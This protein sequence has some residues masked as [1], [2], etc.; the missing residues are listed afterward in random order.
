[1]YLMEKISQKKDAKLLLS[2]ALVSRLFFDTMIELSGSEQPNI[3]IDTSAKA[4]LGAFADTK[5]RFDGHF[6]TLKLSPPTYLE[7]ENAHKSLS[8]KQDQINNAD[9]L[10]TLGGS[11]QRIYENWKS[12]GLDMQI[13]DRVTR[14]KLVAA[15]ASAG[16]MIWFNNGF[17]DSMAEEVEEDE[18]WD[19]MKS[20][21]LE[22]LPYVVTAHHS[23]PDEHGRARDGEFKRFLD[24]S[25][26]V[27]EWQQAIGI[28]TCAG[29]LC[30]DGLLRVVDLKKNAS[31]P[32]ELPG[33]EVYVYT[34]DIS[35]VCSVQLS[36]GDIL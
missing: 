17:S 23:D 36:D 31:N 33:A 18:Y 19:Y 32:D 14:G 4:R 13:I 27:G 9:I 16:S 20:D 6:D 5:G 34:N 3:L 8:A 21:G 11:T 12:L 2:G 1:V 26:R 35:G 22:L 30:A 7:A 15:G 10:L 24:D 28:D 29:L 25:R